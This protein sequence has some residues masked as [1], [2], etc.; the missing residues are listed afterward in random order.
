M[1]RN[2]MLIENK[3]YLHLQPF[4]ILIY[5]SSAGCISLD[6][7]LVLIIFENCEY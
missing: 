5:S 7:D 3:N 1:S 4:H 6:F 2:N